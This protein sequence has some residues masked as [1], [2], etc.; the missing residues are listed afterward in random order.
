MKWHFFLPCAIL[1]PGVQHTADNARRYT[2][3]M[4][5]KATFKILR[6]YLIFTV[7]IIIMMIFVYSEYY[8]ILQERE[9]ET[10]QSHIENELID[11]DRQLSALKDFSLVTG[12]DQRY[13]NLFV[14]ADSTQTIKVSDYILLNQVRDDF[15][16]LMSTLSLI[17]DAGIYFDETTILTKMRSIVNYP[18]SF[19]NNFFEYGGKSAE[20]WFTTLELHSSG[21]ILPVEAITSTDYGTYSGLMYVVAWPPDKLKNHSGILYATIKSA[22]F[23]KHMLPEDLQDT[24]FVSIRNLSGDVLLLK[25]AD[26][27]PDG[28]EL[29]F[30][31]S[32]FTATILVPKSLIKAHLEPVRHMVILICAVLIVLFIS[33]SLIFTHTGL[34]PIKKLVTV[35]DDA[36]NLNSR[37]DNQRNEYDYIADAVAGLDRVADSYAATISLQTG[38]IKSHIFQK[39]AIEGIHNSRQYN[40]FTTFFSDLPEDFILAL[41]SCSLDNVESPGL[42]EL[43]ASLQ[44]TIACRLDNLK[45]LQLHEESSFLMYLSCG[46]N[47]PSHTVQQLTNL[48]AV[49]SDK[50]DIDFT[51]FLSSAHTG[52]KELA[53]AY[54]ELTNL[55]LSY[56]NGALN[57]SLRVVHSYSDVPESAF[58]IALDFN[59][60]Q[61]LYNAVRVGDFE[62]AKSLLDFANNSVGYSGYLDEPFLRQMFYNIRSLFIRVKLENNEKLFD[63]SVPMYD[64]NLPVQA[65]FEP[66]FRCCYDICTRIG[67]L[68]ETSRNEFNETVIEFIRENIGNPDLYVKMAASH[69]GISETTLQKIVQAV[70]GKTF[71]E[72]VDENR[73]E[74]AVNLIQTTDLP[75][76]AISEKCGFS[77]TNTFYKSFKRRYKTSPGALRKTGFL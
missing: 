10:Y 22:D 47:E 4:K 36:K 14:H 70:T 11:I 8:N 24:A 73:M 50:F 74:Q 45:Y 54:S 35:T 65:L 25:N 37:Y 39:A 72:Y 7:L 51:I 19:Y 21:S 16:T 44:S 56:D 63:I 66:L 28:Y 6:T 12:N 52:F 31:T 30:S 29:S 61:Q 59:S 15:R 33:L 20:E 9:R 3:I 75:I 55:K 62:T 68:R 26:S 18:L 67:E 76:A 32:N 71:F 42:A 46:S 43:L 48:H 57:N 40:D 38:V 1:N 27:R 17:S 49:L 64:S 5:H 2:D 58:A 77:S 41:I 13:Q 34:K 69:F 53:L 60:M 23:L